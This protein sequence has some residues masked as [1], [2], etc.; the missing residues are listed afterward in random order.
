MSWHKLSDNEFDRQVKAQL[1]DT[2][3]PYEFSSW[4]KMDKKLDM[5]FPLAGSNNGSVLGLIIFA[6]LLSSVFFWNVSNFPVTANSTDRVLAIED[7]TTQN[8]SIDLL[9]KTEVDESISSSDKTP[10]SET[11]KDQD[12]KAF[13]LE[14][15]ET[16]EIELNQPGFDTHRSDSR[17]VDHYQSQTNQSRIV[18]EP[19]NSTMGAYGSVD[20]KQSFTGTLASKGPRLTNN[21]LV[22]LPVNINSVELL[23]A[24]LPPVIINGSSP[25][26]VGFGYAPDISLV[27]FGETT[28]PGTNLGLAL[29]YQLS[30][31]WSIQT[32]LTYSIKKYKA[33]ADDYYPP[34]GFWYYGNA[35]EETDAECKVIDIPVNV[36][37]YLSSRIK[38]RFFVS[39]GLSTY[40]ML[41]EDYYY[42]YEDSYDPNQLDSWS[43][44]NENQHLFGIYNLSIGYQKSL[45]KQWFLEIEP[46][47]KMPLSGIGFGK[48]DLWSTGSMFSVKYSFK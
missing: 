29:E 43:V 25:F 41:S 24:D 27:G 3:I 23:A 44:N 38:S 42:H 14:S 18:R 31:R 6:L 5:V 32:G 20:Q 26:L 40:L 45:G 37:Y 2:E 11:T 46:F 7:Q 33:T 16:G 1:D 21:I 9:A 36:R 8:R 4:N 10:I 17:P 22:D 13:S 47:I 12:G 39:T 19:E 28:K 15:A 35:P 48:V 34:E 30:S